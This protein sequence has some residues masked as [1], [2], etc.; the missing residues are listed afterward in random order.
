MFDMPGVDPVKQASADLNAIG[1]EMAEGGG[2]DDELSGSTMHR[3]FYSKPEKKS[4][5]PVK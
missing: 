4:T 3:L 5:G 2:S 1:D